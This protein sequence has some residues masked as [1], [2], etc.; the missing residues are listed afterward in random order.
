M[1][2]KIK[3]KFHHYTKWEDFKNGL[4]N[5]SCDFYDEKLN[6]SIEL[7][8]DQEA[9]YEAGIKMCSEWEYSSE[10]NLT[11]SSMNRRAWIGQATCCYN[12]GAPD[13]VTKDAWW[14]LSEDV[15]TLANETA[16]KII[17]NWNSNH[18]MKGSL[19]QK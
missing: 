12:H 14:K 19:W 11:D 6:F 16:D 8:S 10:Q 18:I 15:R 9:F 4:F 3:Q 5:T 13:Y 7:L 1:S 2:F 17:A